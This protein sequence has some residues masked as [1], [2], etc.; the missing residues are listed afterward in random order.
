MKG[1]LEG[2]EGREVHKAVSEEQSD[3]LGAITFRER[4]NL[5][6]LKEFFPKL[7]VEVAFLFLAYL[8]I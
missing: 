2:Y 7:K 3:K 6:V 5:K 8:E 1:G 4:S